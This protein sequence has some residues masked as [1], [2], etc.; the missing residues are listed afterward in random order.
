MKSI[1]NRHFNHF[2]EDT[3]FYLDH[4]SAATVIDDDGSM[5]LYFP[6]RGGEEVPDHVQALTAM[7]I[8]FAEHYDEVM[9]WFHNQMN[10]AN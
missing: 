1:S 8:Y 2:G 9:D 4:T 10:R 7:S 6:E 3:T 5:T